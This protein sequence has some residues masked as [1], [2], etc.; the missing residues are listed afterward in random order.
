[1]SMSVWLIALAVLDAQLPG[2]RTQTNATTSE[3]ARGAGEPSVARQMWRVPH[4]CGVNCLYLFARSHGS[5]IS[6]AELCDRIDVGAAGTSLQ[7]LADACGDIGIEAAV[8]RTTPA[9]LATCSLPAIVHTDNERGGGHFELLVGVDGR[10]LRLI[11]GTTA[12]FHI[13][14]EDAFRRKWSGYVLIA[15]PRTFRTG[16]YLAVL[17]LSLGLLVMGSAVATKLRSHRAARRE[18]ATRGLDV[19]PDGA[20][21]ESR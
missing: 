17:G 5:G 9:R 15:D 4:N 16:T 18:S 10:K 7:Q 19:G 11:D 20:K 21:G 6:Y 13:E 12:V 3:T 14:S 8:I 2:Q 1:M